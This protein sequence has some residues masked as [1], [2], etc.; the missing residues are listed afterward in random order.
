MQAM[1]HSR[2]AL[3]LARKLNRYQGRMLKTQIANISSKLGYYRRKAETVFKERKLKLEQL[4]LMEY[5]V[6]EEIP[7][8]VH[9]ASEASNALGMQSPVSG[10]RSDFSSARSSSERRS[11][12]SSRRPTRG[13]D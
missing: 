2:M 7:V 12:I 13:R 4:M 3:L 6:F 8:Q 10:K 9:L 11:T 1:L 5:A